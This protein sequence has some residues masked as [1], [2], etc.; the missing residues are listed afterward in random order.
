MT[1]VV[2]WLDTSSEEQR[3]V[4]ELIALYAQ[5]ESRDELGIGQIRDAFS[6]ALFPGTS[7]TQTRARYYLFVPWTYTAK[8]ARRRSG[9]A[10]TAWTDLQERRLILTLRDKHR[11]GAGQGLIGRVAGERLK[12]LPSAIYWSGL[13]RYG[14]L[15]AD[16][17]PDQLG[18]RATSDEDEAELS[19]RSSYEW[20]PT[21]PAPPAG[22]PDEV[23]DG[24]DLLPA[25][26]S[27]LRERIIDTTGGSLLA[28]LLEQDRAP[29]GASPAPWLDSACTSA[30]GA[31]AELLRHAQCFSLVVHGAALLYNLLVAE[32]Y[33]AA[34]F[35]RVPEPVAD[36]RERLAQWAD[37]L[38]DQRQ[39]LQHWDRDRFW[40]TVLQLNPR[41][42]V[43][44]RLFVDAWIDAARD[45]RAER[46]ADDDQLRRLVAERE[47]RQK[48]AKQS[49]L[50]NPR[51]LP[52][53]S[54]QSGTGRLD[55]RW[56]TVR[57]IVTD[58]FEG[59]DRA[60]A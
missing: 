28:H 16:I 31:T 10:L 51:L 11:L 2:A 45:G 41:I 8:G 48:G 17:A 42:G 40:T 25:E 38:R 19:A 37:E 7:V 26:A 14:I 4:R 24:L 33:E 29:D 59:L 55:Y 58:V 53:W 43:Q 60:A 36:H 3:R 6:E 30:T 20:H 12:I 49:R 27:W 18:R 15:A 1:S 50:E 22:W 54:G 52:T 47:R 9:G 13:I 23:P 35:N 34:G 44:T 32:R 56:G 46:C 57:R 39:L 21:L 5:N